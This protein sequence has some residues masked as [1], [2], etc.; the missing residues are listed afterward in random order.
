MTLCKYWLLFTGQQ[1]CLLCKHA[2]NITSYTYTFISTLN[3]NR[4]QNNSYTY[5]NSYN[6]YIYLYQI[7]FKNFL[8]KIQAFFKCNKIC[9]SKSHVTTKNNKWLVTSV[10]TMS[11]TQN[12]VCIVYICI[13]IFFLESSRTGVHG[14]MQKRCW[15]LFRIRW[16]HKEKTK[17]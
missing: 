9:N 17:K 13:V 8:L 12:D 16:E 1:Q 14:T 15:S 3:D 10:P 5:I 2:I 11:F 4:I 7:P 6:W